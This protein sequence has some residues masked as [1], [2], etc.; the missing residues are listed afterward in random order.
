MDPTEFIT[1]VMFIAKY[2]NKVTTCTWCISNRGIDF[3]VLKITYR[4]GVTHHMVLN[5][6]ELWVTA[7]QCTKETSLLNIMVKRP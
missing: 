5:I 1:E 4:V 3:I 2:P 6:L 7:V